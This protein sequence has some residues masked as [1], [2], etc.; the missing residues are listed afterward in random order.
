MASVLALPI[1]LA[2]ITTATGAEPAERGPSWRYFDSNGV[3]I[4]YKVHGRGEP[5]LLIHGLAADAQINWGTPGI[6][7][8]LAENYLVIAMDVRGHGG[9]D[10]PEKAEAY[11]LELV[12]DVIRLLDHLKLKNA[13][14]IGY[15]MGGM[16]ALKLAADHPS[17]VRSAALGGMGWL[18]SGSNLQHFWDSLPE[19]KTAWS[20]AIAARSLGALAVSEEQLKAIRIPVTVFIGDQDPI[21]N[22]YVAPLQVVRPDWSVTVIENASHMNCPIKPAFKAGLKAWLDAQS[23]RR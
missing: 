13:H 15:S 11:G 14:I 10:K 19:R 8:T 18:R 3:S 20:P 22:L 1:S 12:L 21:R 16:I 5:V 9:S 17:R 4:R 2:V 7:N 23:R 6:I